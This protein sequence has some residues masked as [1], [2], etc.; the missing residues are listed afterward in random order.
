MPRDS[1]PPAPPPE[2]PQPS[3]LRLGPLLDLLEAQDPALR[4]LFAKAQTHKV[5]QDRWMQ[6]RITL[7]RVHHM[8][9]IRLELDPDGLYETRLRTMVPEELFDAFYFRG[10][11]LDGKLLGGVSAIRQS[12]ASFLHDDRWQEAPL[13][14]HAAQ[15][16]NQLHVVCTDTHVAIPAAAEAKGSTPARMRR[17]AAKNGLTLGVHVLR[18]PEEQNFWVN[19]IGRGYPPPNRTFRWCTQ[20]LKIDPVTSFVERPLRRWREAI[21]HLR[22]RRAESPTR[23]QTLAG[24]ETP[25]GLTRHPELPRVWVSNPIEYTMAPKES[26]R[27]CLSARTTGA[28]TIVRF[29]GSVSALN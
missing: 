29:A 26:G 9:D 15:P 1:T 5:G 16:T 12:L 2:A 23:A 28:A 17:C 25:K 3:Q 10:E 27:G 6:P 24:R 11:P 19:I 18:P 8:P 14:M 21:L 4:R 20:R 22:A 13:A 7:S